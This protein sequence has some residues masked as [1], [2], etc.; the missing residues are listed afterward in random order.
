VT[1]IG[2]HKRYAGD[3]TGIKFVF[4]DGYRGGVPEIGGEVASQE[5]HA[6]G[7]AV[8]THRLANL[9]VYGVVANE[10]SAD[11]KHT[12]WWG[13]PAG[14]AKSWATFGKNRTRISDG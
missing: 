10:V 7:N 5:P 2:A 3:F 8:P 11:G 12:N 9:G 13:T 1:G 4:P 6:A 14:L